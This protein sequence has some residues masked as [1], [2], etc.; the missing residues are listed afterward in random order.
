MHKAEKAGFS[1]WM[2]FLPSRSVERGSALRMNWGIVSRSPPPPCWQLHWTGV[3]WNDGSDG[4]TG[5]EVR[6]SS[7]VSPSLIKNL[8]DCPGPKSDARS[9]VGFLTTRQLSSWQEVLDYPML[10]I[11]Q[12]VIRRD[13]TLSPPR[14]RA[15]LPHVGWRNARQRR[16]S[17]SLR[18]GPAS[19]ACGPADPEERYRRLAGKYWNVDSHGRYPRP[20][21]TRSTVANDIAF[22]SET[23]AS[24]ERVDA[25]GARDSYAKRQASRHMDIMP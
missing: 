23:T 9:G 6:A 4:G 16:R 20:E 3:Q 21:S 1:T 15:G 8:V 18:D 5:S 10:R 17:R 24:R 19:E 2:V 11:A 13:V 7:L 14:H 25:P 12:R 22:G